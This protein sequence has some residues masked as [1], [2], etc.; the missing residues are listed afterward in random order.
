MSG[1]EGGREGRRGERRERKRGREERK[2]EREGGSGEKERRDLP[3][4]GGRLRKNPLEQK[5]LFA[6]S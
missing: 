4:I 1:R 2:E 6:S 5:R 3:A